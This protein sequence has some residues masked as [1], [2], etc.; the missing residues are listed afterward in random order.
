MEYYDDDQEFQLDIE[1]EALNVFSNL[2]KLLKNKLK[3]YKKY[4]EKYQ[5]P[6]LNQMLTDIQNIIDGYVE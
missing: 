4:I 2:R 5:D 1:L 3:D 6:N